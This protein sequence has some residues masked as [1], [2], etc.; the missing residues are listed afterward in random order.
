MLPA[1]ILVLAIINGLA[2]APADTALD[3]VAALGA[4]RYLGQDPGAKGAQDN[5]AHCT[6]TLI[7][8]AVALT[9]RHCIEHVPPTPAPPGGPYA[10]RFRRALDGSVGSLAAGPSSFYHVLVDHTYTLPGPATDENEPALL[11]LAEIVPHIEG[12]PMVFDPQLGGG[13]PVTLAGWGLDGPTLGAGARGRLLRCQSALMPVTW[14]GPYWE[15]YI[16]AEQHYDYWPGCGINNN[17][18]GS[19]VL[20]AHPQTGAPRVVAV[21]IRSYLAV[22]TSSL[23]EDQAFAAVATPD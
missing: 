18:S 4:A 16:P 11:Y 20:A 14:P 5:G 15:T 13:L 10:L 1:A 22:R 23:A 17:D 21:V 7:G 8:S 19:P 12:M 6:A 2:P 3:P 9:A